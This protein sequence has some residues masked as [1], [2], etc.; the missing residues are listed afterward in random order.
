M[1]R[2]AREGP[3]GSRSHT[4]RCAPTNAPTF[5]IEPSPLLERIRVEVDATMIQRA[6]LCETTTKRC[7]QRAFSDPA[8]A[9]KLT[10][11]QRGCSGVAGLTTLSGSVGSSLGGEDVGVVPE[12]VEE[13]RGELLVAEDLDPFREG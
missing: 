4:L 1:H 3:N 2:R 9:I 12:A 10:H 7:T 13:G 6:A 11:P 8:N 5:R